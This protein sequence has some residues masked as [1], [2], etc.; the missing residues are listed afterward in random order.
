MDKLNLIMA[1]EE[2]YDMV[3]I[4]GNVDV[5]MSYANAGALVD[6]NPYLQYTPNIAAAVSDYARDIFTVGD[7]LY[8]LGMPA[9]SFNGGQ[10][11]IREISWIRKDWLDA[12]GL[13]VPETLD[14]FTEMLRA[15]KSYNNG[16]SIATIP[17]TSG[18]GGVWLHSVIGAFGIP[19]DW[20][21][22]D[23]K[24]LPRSADPRFKEYLTYLKGL[25]QEGLLDP[26]Y[27][28]NQ[29]ANVREK[30][31]NG[32]AGTS[33]FGYWDVPGLYDTMEQT[34]PGFEIAFMPPLAGPDGKK[35]FGTNVGGFDRICF[36]PKAGKNLEHTLNFM[37]IKLE[38][39]NFR[40]AVIGFENVHWTQTEDGQYW[41]IIPRFFDDFSQGVNY[42]TGRL[43][44]YETY[45]MARAK[46]DTRQWECWIQLNGDPKFTDFNSTSEVNKAPAF[47]ET[48]KNKQSI[49]QMV[50]DKMVKVI[51]GEDTVESY[52]E[53]LEE[54][55]AAGGQ[56]MI[57]EYNA[58][59]ATF[60][61]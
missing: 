17:L 14:E 23:G 28:A 60:S 22:V 43:P 40:S 56:A 35:A 13:S 4:G 34:Q 52:D 8:A 9:L 57:D 45:W 41:P 18:T 20:N 1:S 19:N 46:K 6:L 12:L 5:T 61:S 24:I 49:D 10:G 58:W 53:F 47:P 38:E 54:W 31:S 2:S 33:Q 3:V 48:S 15:F 36:L 29:S 59:W 27:P 21:V 11:E 37:N 30:F 32:I 55:K 25:Y 39:E 50:A 44:E 51:A 26:E 16:S 7:S 42:T